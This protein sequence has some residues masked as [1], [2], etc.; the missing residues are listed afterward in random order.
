MA[1]AEAV[2]LFQCSVND[3]YKIISD[4]ER[5]PEFLS[6]VKSCHVI[7]T[8]G[9]RKLVE[10][11]VSVIKTFKYSLWMA[12][13]SSKE[14]TWELAGGD[15][16]KESNGFW[17]LEDEA[18]KTRAIYH[19]DAHFK[20]FVPSPIAKALVQVNLPTMMSSYHKRVSELCHK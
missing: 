11:T 15:L 8:E 7:K 5:Y 14:L 9:N 1:T 20:V 2:E 19:V 18:G 10:Y 4:Y 12:E 17:R 13:S 16:F 3:F 6:E